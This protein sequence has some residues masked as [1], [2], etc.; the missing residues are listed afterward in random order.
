MPSHVA[1]INVRSRLTQVVVLVVL[2]LSCVLISQI[3]Q[4]QH[5]GKAI[6]YD[7]PKFRIAVH[8]NSNKA[9]YIMF[10]KRTSSP[11]GSLYASN[12]RKKDTYKALAETDE[13][14]RLA[15]AN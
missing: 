3:A 2:I 9:C 11:K 15:N 14:A 4:A 7:H 12:T 1:N 6:R 8:S 5:R 10:K 13:P